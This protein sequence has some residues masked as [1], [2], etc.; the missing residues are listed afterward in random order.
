MFVVPLDKARLH[1]LS[2]FSLRQ[3]GTFLLLQ[4]IFALRG[5]NNLQE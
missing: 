2:S 1:A 5:E 3:H 4:V